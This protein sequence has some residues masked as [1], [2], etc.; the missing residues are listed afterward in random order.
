MS[1]QKEKSKIHNTINKVIKGVVILALFVFIVFVLKNNAEFSE[2][3]A[4][5]G[6]DKKVSRLR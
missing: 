6:P 2:T 4:V 1:E 5:G 3:V